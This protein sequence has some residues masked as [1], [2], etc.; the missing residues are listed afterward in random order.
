[1]KVCVLADFSACSAVYFEN[2]ESMHFGG[3]LA[4][5]SAD[6]ELGKLEFIRNVDTTA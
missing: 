1:M 6:G 3:H 2:T 4:S 5:S